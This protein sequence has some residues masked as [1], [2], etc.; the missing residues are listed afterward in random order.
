MVT[1]GLVGTS[2]SVP[3]ASAEGPPDLRELLATCN[4]D[5]GVSGAVTDFQGE[6]VADAPVLVHAERVTEERRTVQP[7]LGATR[8]DED[9]C[10]FVPLR[11][12]RALAG[13]ADISGWVNLQVTLQRPD[14]LEMVNLPHR[15]VM[16]HGKARFPAVHQSFGLQADQG[17]RTPHVGVVPDRGPLP[18]DTDAALKYVVLKRVKTYRKRPVLVGQ[19]FSTLKGVEQ[20][21][22]YSE[23]ASSSLGS[24]SSM[25]GKV[26]SFEKSQTYSR[27]TT[28]TV[29][30]PKARGKVGKYYRTYF[31]YARYAHVYCDGVDCGVF[32]YS[33]R[34]YKWERGTQVISN[35]PQF[36]VDRDNCSRY[37]P[38]S[39]DT[40]GGSTAITWTDGVSLGTE[41]AGDIGVH[42]SLSART[43]FTSDAENVVHFNRGGLLCGKYGPLSGTPRILAARPLRGRA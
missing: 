39:W 24:V 29:T 43:G 25:T 42:V 11:A 34:P 31:S 19:W 15:L 14:G 3:A 26:G 27:S 30:F 4:R 7:L 23:G 13:L 18:V 40:S 5:D 37:A 1:L 10:Y 9:G 20:T 32:K 28:A 16:R 8:T 12:G 21:W 38:D 2:L 33:V 17:R 35:I 6:P 41:L 22:R 36:K